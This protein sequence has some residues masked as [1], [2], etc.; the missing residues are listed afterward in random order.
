MDAA[1]A[2]VLELVKRHGRDA[3]SFQVLEPEF[4][5]WFG[6]D[7]TCV[8][9]VDTGRA[10]VAAGAPIADASRAPAAAD[11]FV[12]AARAAG[13]RVAFFAT[14]APFVERTPSLRALAIGQQPVWRPAD[15]PATV[16]TTAGLRAQLR[17]AHR[18]GVRVL[19]LAPAELEP[20]EAPARKE[21]ERLMSRWLARKALPPMGF[22]LQLHAFSHARERLSFVARR[23]GRVVGFLSAVPVYAR[24]GWLFEDLL[25]DPAAPNGTSEVLF[26]A[27][28][29]AARELGSGYATLGLAPLAGD[30]PWWLELARTSTSPLYD[31]RGLETFKAKLKPSAWAPVFLSYL[32]E[33]GALR[34][35]ADALRAFAREHLVAY[36]ARALLRGVG[37]AGLNAMTP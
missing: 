13:R 4:R 34:T 10:W 32:P 2:R 11:A 8:A 35:I 20:P 7:D 37:L 12:A 14:E 25:R 6:G 22:L 21:I 33:H 23:Q 28:M 24:G 16:A 29:T 1:R 30:V 18:K 31:F 26:D 19:R 36:G 3:T 27:A 5:H 15:W 9:Y 17:R